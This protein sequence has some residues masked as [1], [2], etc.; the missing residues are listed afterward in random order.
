MNIHAQPN[1]FKNQSPTTHQDRLI[2]GGSRSAF[3]PFARTDLEQSIP[4]R[5]E[6]QARRHAHRLAAR[7]PNGVSVTYG[8]LNR[9]ANVIGGAVLDAIGKGEAPVV[10]LM[11]QSVGLLAAIMG[12]LKAGKFYVP[13]DPSQGAAAIR[14]VTEDIGAPLI[15]TDTANHAL[16]TKLGDGQM[17]VINVDDIPTDRSTENIGLSLS[18]NCR[19]YVYY[20]SGTTGRPKGVV[21]CHRNV[22]HNVLRYTNKLLIGSDDRLSL[23]QSPGF[24]GAVSNI[25]CALLN[26]ASVFPY[27]LRHDGVSNLAA[28][29]THEELTMFHA[30]PAIY[31]WLFAGH[32]RFHTLR[33][34]RLEGDQAF[35]HHVELFSDRFTA[36]CSLVV[37]LGT[38]ETGIATQFVIDA[39]GGFD[40]ESVPIGRPAEDMSVRLLDETGSPVEQGDIG[41]IVVES[42]YLALGYWN[43]PEATEAAFGSAEGDHSRRRYRTGDL[44]RARPDG[45]IEYLGRKENQIRIRGHLVDIPMVEET[46]RNVP[47]IKAAAVVSQRDESGRDRLIAYIVP[48]AHGCFNVGQLREDLSGKLLG[49]NMPTA[50]I[51]LTDL[52]LNENNKLDRN[53]LPA[54]TRRRPDLGRDYAPPTTTAERRLTQVWEEVLEL[55]PVGIH[56]D[57]FDLGGDSLCAETLFAEVS[58]VFGLCLPTWTVYEESATVARM[59]AMIES[60][61]AQ[62]GARHGQQDVPEADT[63]KVIPCMPRRELTKPTPLVTKRDLGAVAKLIIMA[64]L[65]C[66][67]GRAV[68]GSLC[69]LI[70]R[71]L[72]AFRA[73]RET[74]LKDVIPLLDTPTTAKALET[75][76]LA[77]DYLAI[78]ETWRQHAPWNRPAIAALRG[79]E[80]IDAAIAAGRGAVL[81]TCSTGS[82]SR[83]MLRSLADAGIP[84]AQLRGYGHPFSDSRFAMKFLNPVSNR[85]DDRYVHATVLVHEENTIEVM[86]ALGDHLN[87][88][89]VV[90]MDA[91]GAFGKPY[92]FPFFGGTLYLALGAPTLALRHDAPL[93]PVFCVP[94]GFGFYELV[95][96]E[97]LTDGSEKASADAARALARR[98]IL[99]LERYLKR[100]PVIWPNWFMRNT[101][102]PDADPDSGKHKKPA[103]GPN[104]CRLR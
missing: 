93:I 44:G 9:S 57:F 54:L 74:D 34:I 39:E 79:R 38:T 25:F 89:G 56:D 53:A 90:Q 94:D 73:S 8:E 55:E 75:E 20:T 30:V 11:N 10:I 92:R 5:F 69:R 80:H 48:T 45:C 68:R 85:M 70:A 13:V 43:R 62:S 12:T 16:A 2:P 76:L 14:L 1:L 81:W 87:A 95:I 17:Q 29:V 27:D 60:E 32:H 3:E 31:E 7:D 24:S 82:G 36:R 103:G 33:V 15:L 96:E 104:S 28:W 40:G 78:A 6:Q 91:N 101:W 4:D 88:N 49:P 23:V 71:T 72:M 99:I 18:P 35:K 46:I 86:R 50:F 59:A 84:V 51:E 64:A 41:E 47:V 58:A 22:L 52:P 98:Y 19:A 63:D 61:A 67:P 66:L 102:K 77:G 83:S 97:P 21:D 100:H 37:G 26:G 65:A 42:A